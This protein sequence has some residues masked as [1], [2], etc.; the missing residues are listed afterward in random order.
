MASALGTNDLQVPIR[1]LH[2][3]YLPVQ[4]LELLELLGVLK[5]LGLLE[6]LL[7]HIRGKFGK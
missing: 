6:S 2:I 4:L 5:L 1:I 3:R 7:T